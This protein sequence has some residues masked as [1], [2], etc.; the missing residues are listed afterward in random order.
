MNFAGIPVRRESPGLP[1]LSYLRARRLTDDLIDLLIETIHRIGARAERKVERELLN[2]IKRV[3]GKQNLLFD[4]T[5]AQPDG[6]TCC[7]N[8]SCFPRPLR[9]CGEGCLDYPACSSTPF[10]DVGRL[11]PLPGSHPQDEA[12]AVLETLR[13]DLFG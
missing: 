4:A 9:Q 13:H 5:L 10:G 1:R 12:L 3:G 2:D 6:V 7:A 8:V 11:R